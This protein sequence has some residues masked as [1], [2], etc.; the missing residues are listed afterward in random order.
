M[1][2]IFTELKNPLFEEYLQFKKIIFESYNLQWFFN[3]DTIE[4]SDIKRKQFYF[5]SH[6]ILSRGNPPVVESQP[7]YVGCKLMV[8]NILNF[9]NI[10]LNKIYRMCLN[11]THYYNFKYNNPHV[12]HY[13]PH[14]NMIIYLNECHGD[15]VIFK[16]KY[17]LDRDEF[18]NT[19]NFHIKH[20][21]KPKEDKIISFDGSHF[22]C[23]SFPKPH[24]R[25]VVFVCT[26]D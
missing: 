20:R 10:N 24:Q 18:Y 22:H 3:E 16:E 1:S 23:H 5:Y 9:N 13:H 6:T 8:E 2:K 14:K 21:I 4:S 15:T 17:G 12:D 19:Y 11:A 25:R 7:L 26:Y